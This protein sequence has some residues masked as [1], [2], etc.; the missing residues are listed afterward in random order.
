MLMKKTNNK[1]NVHRNWFCKLKWMERFYRGIMWTPF[2]KGLLTKKLARR[3]NSALLTYGILT[4]TYLF[5]LQLVCSVCLLEFCCDLLKEPEVALQ[6]TLGNRNQF[7]SR[8]ALTGILF[9]FL[10]SFFFPFFLFLFWQSSVLRLLCPPP[11][12]GAMTWKW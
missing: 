7:G 9:F 8:D 6:W 4:L 5:L 12:L 3:A 2:R 10:F 1:Q 11:Q